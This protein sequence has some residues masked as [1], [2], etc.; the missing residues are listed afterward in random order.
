MYC[1]EHKYIYSEYELEWDSLFD[2]NHITIDK[3]ISNDFYHKWKPY[4]NIIC[5]DWWLMPI[6]NF[7]L[8]LTLSSIDSSLV[9]PWTNRSI[10]NLVRLHNIELLIYFRLVHS[11]VCHIEE[12]G[13]LYEALHVNYSMCQF[14]IVIGHIGCLRKMP[15]SI[16]KMKK[17]KEKEN[18][19]IN[20]SLLFYVLEQYVLFELLFDILWTSFF[21]FIIFSCNCCL[22]VCAMCRRKKAFVS[23]M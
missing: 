8:E 13:N 3:W 1:I 16:L 23:F 6:D 7:N 17:K 2:V 12:N 19:H 21:F 5:D 15:V 20:I 22:C 10:C 4:P 18:Y 11:L 14:H 9:H